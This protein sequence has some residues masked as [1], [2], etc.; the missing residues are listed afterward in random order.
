MLSGTRRVESVISLDSVSKS[1]ESGSVSDSGDDD[2]YD[3]MMSAGSSSILLD[4]D[5]PAWSH[6]AVST[7][8]EGESASSIPD[9]A[10]T[11]YTDGLD[12]L[13]LYR[14]VVAPVVD[15]MTAEIIFSCLTL[16]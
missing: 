8:E 4:E 9:A 2:W 6:L 10:M 1:G 14:D 16:P 15:E 12:E 3:A 7:H 13:I 5:H 11:D